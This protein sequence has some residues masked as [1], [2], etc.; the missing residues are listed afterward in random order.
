MDNRKKTVVC[1]RG[2]LIAVCLLASSIASAQS[3]SAAGQRVLDVKCESVNTLIARDSAA[4]AVALSNPAQVAEKLS[5]GEPIVSSL[6]GAF[7]RAASGSKILAAEC[8]EACVAAGADANVCRL[9]CRALKNGTCCG[10]WELAL[11]MKRHS[12]KKGAEAMLLTYNALCSD[13]RRN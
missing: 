10:L 1:F 8:R 7:V 5:R 2:A 12:Q 6:S 3:L 13:G 4:L 11:H 9:G